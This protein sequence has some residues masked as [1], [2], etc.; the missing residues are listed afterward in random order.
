M[1]MNQGSTCFQGTVVQLARSILMLLLHLYWIPILIWHTPIELH[2][3]LALLGLPLSSIHQLSCNPAQ[4]NGLVAHKKIIEMRVLQQNIGNIS[5]TE[6]F[7]QAA[8]KGLSPNHRF[9]AEVCNVRIEF[10]EST[11][12]AI[13]YISFMWKCGL[14]AINIDNK[15][16][17]KQLNI[18][19]KSE[20]MT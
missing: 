12:F 1:N 11:H 13:F 17:S 19:L 15:F 16:L 18:R 5:Y 9:Q 6:K 2:H 3:H 14:N 20:P 7:L 8:G 10:N 4:S